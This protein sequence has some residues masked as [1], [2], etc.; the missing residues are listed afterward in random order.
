MNKE[1]RPV[2]IKRDFMLTCHGCGVYTTYIH[3]VKKDAVYVHV[4]LEYDKHNRRP[5]VDLSPK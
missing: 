5:I 2:L 1:E 4:I 3:D